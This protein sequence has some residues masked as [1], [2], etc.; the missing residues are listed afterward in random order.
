MIQEP[1]ANERQRFYSEL[2]EYCHLDTL[3]MVLILKEMQAMST[4][5]NQP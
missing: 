4:D 2:L 3:A 5:R 1:D